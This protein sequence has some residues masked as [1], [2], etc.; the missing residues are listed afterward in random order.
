MWWGNRKIAAGLTGLLQQAP[1]FLV[2]T[3]A[4]VLAVHLVLRGLAAEVDTLYFSWT[5]VLLGAFFVA[6]VIYLAGSRSVVSWAVIA[7]M[8]ALHALGIISTLKASA[9]TFPLTWLDMLMFTRN[10]SGL[11]V[12]VGAPAWSYGALWSAPLLAAGLA[13]VLLY[14]AWRRS[15]PGQFLFG[16]AR[17][18]AAAFVVVSAMPF[19]TSGVI[20]SIEG[21][22]DRG[23]VK[24]DS[25]TGEGLTAF[26]RQIGE[27]QFLIF[28]REAA[29]NGA[30]SLFASSGAPGLSAPE[31]SGA[32]A[33]AIDPAALGGDLPNIIL[34]HAESTFDPN[35][36]LMLERPAVNSLFYTSPEAGRGKDVHLH[37]AGLANVIGG[38]SW[39]SEFEVLLGLDSRLFGMD[40]LYTHASLSHLA[41]RTFVRYLTERGYHA[42]AYGLDSPE[43]YNWTTAYRNYGFDEVL[44]GS[45]FGSPHTD[46]DTLAAVLPL[47]G[48][49]AS[50]PFFAMVITVGNHSPHPCPTAP[51]PEAERASLKGDASREQNCALNEYLR[52]AR[53]T[54]AAVAQA[55]EFLAAEERRT[56]RPYVLALYGDHQPYTFTGNGSAEMNLGLDF[57][58]F[59]KDAEKRRTVMKIHASKRNPF[60]CCTGDV[61]PLSSLPTLISAYVA[62]DPGQIYLPENLY[63]QARCGADWIGSLARSFN[64][65][66]E[67]STRG[68]CDAYEALKASYA[69]SGV[70]GVRGANDSVAQA[71]GHRAASASPAAGAAEGATRSC[72]GPEADP[73]SRELILTAAGTMYR[74]PPAFRVY[75]DGQPVGEAEIRNAFDTAQTTPGD[76]DLAG[77]MEDYIFTLPGPSAG[78]RQVEVEFSNDEWAGEGQTGDT[79]LFL[80]SVSVGGARLPVTGFPLRDSRA[81]V[82]NRGQQRLD[83]YG[84]ARVT[85]ELCHDNIL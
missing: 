68:R 73:Q 13:A 26:S 56:G 64:W 60:R 57:S 45:R 50:R 19:V 17:L 30:E 47:L 71:A 4:Y 83:F 67:E 61:I 8:A 18:G 23:G 79:N 63:R 54:E 78:V 22:R 46:A 14:R 76:G 35:D 62:P 5:S 38:Y 49:D 42:S 16:A 31:L 36:V 40:G 3:A 34:I 24:G 33:G 51:V 6:S 65:R 10:P 66:T 25:F 75:A 7:F 55:R 70:I 85:F 43:F 2:E 53:S 28:S 29:G 72:L 81:V 58:A 84:N 15:A 21:F 74:H 41:Q 77:R 1:R 80:K 48:G 20:G 59:R 52:R 82:L 37:T 44:D 12:S 32:L 27:L 9:V 11:L 39:V 69:M